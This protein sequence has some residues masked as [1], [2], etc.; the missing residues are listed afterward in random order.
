[1]VHVYEKSQLAVRARGVAVVGKFSTLPVSMLS[2]KLRD[3]FYQEVSL[4]WMFRD[5]PGFARVF[6]FA[7]SPTATILMEY[8]PLGALQYYVSPNRRTQVP[9]Q[10]PYTKRQVLSLMHD[11]AYAFAAMH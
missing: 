1:M 2:V 4:H 3:A 7:E 10:F 9:L 8:Y 6:G 5:T 11:C